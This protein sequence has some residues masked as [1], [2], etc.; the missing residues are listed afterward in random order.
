MLGWG[1]TRHFAAATDFRFV[2]DSRFGGSGCSFGAFFLAVMSLS[3][4]IWGY[5]A[6][7]PVVPRLTKLLLGIRINPNT[8]R[9]AAQ[10]YLE[11]PVD[12]VCH[13]P[14]LK[15]AQ[16]LYQNIY[17]LGMLWISFLQASGKCQLAGFYRIWFY[18]WCAPLL[19]AGIR[20]HQR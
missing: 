19:M 14:P 13:L 20:R 3:F 15:V 1:F 12:L 8:P 18:V 16:T 7:L 5:P 9:L 17:S 2:S 6:G 11:R 10:L 4:L